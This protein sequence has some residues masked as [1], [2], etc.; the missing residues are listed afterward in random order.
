MDCE[1]KGGGGDKEVAHSSGSRRGEVFFRGVIAFKSSL[2]VC[3]C[4]STHT[5]KGEAV[6]DLTC[7]YMK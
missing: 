4:V 5:R 2:F 7:G 6:R 3:V 1:D